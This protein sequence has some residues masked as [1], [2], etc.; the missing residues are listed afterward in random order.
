MIVFGNQLKAENR[1]DNNDC[2]LQHCRSGNETAGFGRISLHPYHTKT[3]HGSSMQAKPALLFP[4]HQTFTRAKVT[5]C[6]QLTAGPSECTQAPGSLGQAC[7]CWD[8]TLTSRWVK[9][10]ILIRRIT[11]PGGQQR[12]WSQSYGFS[13]VLYRCRV[14]DHQES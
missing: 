13:V 8:F 7:C 4:N 12:S 10:V 6:C 14:V 5:S 11:L 9:G 1:Q 2:G 3:E